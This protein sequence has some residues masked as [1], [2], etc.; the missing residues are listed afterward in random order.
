MKRLVSGL[1][2]LTACLFTWPASAQDITQ[3]VITLLTD[4]GAQIP[5]ILMHPAN[6]IN[7]HNPGVVIQHGGMDGHPARGCCAPR[8]AAAH[9]ARL[10]YTTVSPLSR[11]SS[12]R[13]AGSYR[14]EPFKTATLDIKAAVDFL[15]QLGAQDIVLA[16]HSMGSIRITRYM[17]ETQDSRVKAMVHYAPTRDLSEWMR[18][19]MGEERYLGVIDRLSTMVAEGRGDDYV[20]EVYEMAPPA[21]PGLKSSSLQMAR[22][23]LDWWGPAAQTRNTVWFKDIHVP[24]LL[25]S[26]DADTFVTIPFLEQLKASALNSPRVEYRWYEG[27]VD[28]VFLGAR[29]KA[30]Q[31]TTDWLT[32]L[33]LGPRPAVTTRFVDTVTEDGQQRSGVYYAPADGSAKGKPAF[34]I[35]YGGSGDIMWSSNHWLCVRLAQAGHACLAGQTRGSGP[36][37]WLMTLEAEVPDFGAWSRWLGEQG[38]DEV[39]MAGHS[40]GGI[41]ITHYMVDQQDPRIKGMVYLAP[42]V[43]GPAYME[44]NM[45]QE[46]YRAI[47]SEAE[48]IAKTGEP[49]I[50]VAKYEMAPPAPPNQIV[51][52]PQTAVSFLSHWGPNANT[53]HTEQIR[54]VTLPVLSITPV[55]LPP[56]PEC[57]P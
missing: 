56:T 24:I 29:G 51:A 33:G 50:V 21:P 2:G 18:E 43:D 19:N 35:V 13:N 28:H 9:M 22:I 5:A 45:G 54:K 32:D 3:N 25:L 14:R 17:V 10:G 12:G 36:A 31:D 52:R 39:I 42:T 34:M 15:D 4:D 55:P 48:A 37:M 49:G 8:W 16:G 26:G 6:G 44:R 11:H 27:G 47:V 53:V 41:R 7:T 46:A 23:W 40:W 30:A 1:I 38:Y 20:Y 57:L